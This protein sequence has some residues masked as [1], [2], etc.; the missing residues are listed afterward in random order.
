MF[1]PRTRPRK[2]QLIRATRANELGLTQVLDTD[3]AIDPAKMAEALHALPNQPKP[4]ASEYDAHLDGLEKIC[5]RIEHMQGSS[6]AGQ[7]ANNTND[8]SDAPSVSNSPRS[9][10]PPEE[11]ALT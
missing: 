3:N 6:L 8:S 7:L 9:A 4:S 2:E 11:H 1:V 5:D 10:Q